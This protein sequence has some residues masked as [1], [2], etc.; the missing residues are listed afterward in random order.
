MQIALGSG[1]MQ[2]S[3]VAGSSRDWPGEAGHQGNMRHRI[4]GFIEE[5]RSRSVFRALAAYTVVAWM[6]LQVADVTFDRLPI[7]AASMTVLIILVIAGFPV[8]LILAWAYEVTERGI[9]R[10]DEAGETSRRLPFLPFVGAVA[11]VTVA[12]GAGLY[13]LSQVYWEPP[14]RSIAVLPFANASDTA[15]AEYFSD[16]LTEEVRSLIVRLG[17]FN[18]VATAS[19]GQFRESALRIVEIAE[20]LSAGSV[21]MGSVRKINNEVSV[22]A[23]L[24]DGSD[25]SE[26]WSESYRRELADL[27]AIQQDIAREVARALHVVLPVETERRLRRLGS[28]NVEAYDLYLRAKDYLREQADEV[29]LV[30]AEAFARQALALDPN[31]ASAQAALCQVH[32]ARYQSSRDAADFR[33]GESACRKTLDLDASNADVHLALGGLYR[34]SGDYRL[35]G[36]EYQKAIELNPRLPDAWIGL[37]YAQ[38]DSNDAALAEA[39]FRRAIDVDV[40]YWGSF[41]A[42]GN[43]LID[44]GR[45]AEAAEFYRLFA[46]RAED[47]A[48]ALN[49]LGGAYYFAGDFK[50]AAKAWDASIAIKPTRSAYSNTATMYF[51]LGEFQKAADRYA[52]AVAL[53]PKDHRLWGNLADAYFFS[54]ELQHAAEVAYRRAVSLAEDRLGVNPNEFDTMSDLAY[55]HCRLGD[56][57]TS[58]QLLQRALRAAPEDMYVHY[59]SALINVQFGETD[60][61]LAAVKRAIELEYKPE[62]LSIDPGLRSLSADQRFTRIIDEARL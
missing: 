31:F 38:L 28:T 27:V 24:I 59:Y 17:E 11:A 20:R 29:T 33:S 60:A 61:A 2:R 46:N 54:E 52:Q 53:S 22:T 6:L 37:G 48:V 43:F 26:L 49:N 12:C 40:S 13:F 34:A 16:G 62:L 42:M 36:L 56:R 51:Y 25:G 39:S 47:D 44:Q 15:D 21:L 1:T 19:S 57:Q 30:Q 7:P 41:Q 8:T 35:A 5:L 14:Q 18:V 4:S 23:R 45:F 50:Q 32:L 3:R 58:E 10:H 9:V 55:Y